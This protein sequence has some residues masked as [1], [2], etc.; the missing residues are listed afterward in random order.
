MS[1]EKSKKESL[2]NSQNEPKEVL[3]GDYIIKKTIGTG[4]FSTVK[5]G[6]H[7]ITQKKVAVKI[8]DKNKIESKDDL[9]RIIREMQIL[10]EMDHQNVIKIFKIYEEEDNFSII[11]EYCEGG[12]LFNYIVK[13]QRLS[14]DETCFFFYQIINGIEYI[15]SKGIAHRDLKP[16]NLLIGKNQILKIIDFGLSNFYDG[17]KRLETPCGSPCYAS[18]EMVKGKKYDGFNIDI[19]AIGVI[20]FAMLCGYL[21]FE[22]DENDNDILFSQIIKNK[23]DYPSFLSELS[24]DM[25]KKILVSDPLKRITVDEIKKHDFYLKGEKIY[26]ERFKKVEEVIN[27]EKNIGI[28]DKIA[29]AF[30]N[31][32][33]SDK[34]II[35][36]TLN[37]K[38]AEK[39]IE[40]TKNI[41][42]I[43]DNYEK[44]KDEQI[45]NNN[46]NN[47]KK[48]NNE[49]H[50]DENHNDEIN[51]YNNEKK[52][53]ENNVK[54]N[55]VENNYIEKKIVE[56]TEN[57]EKNYIDK[58]SAEKNKDDKSQNILFLDYLKSDKA[59]KKNNI[60][61]KAPVSTINKE[62]NNNENHK[63]VNSLNYTINNEIIKTNT[64]KSTNI[65]SLTNNTN[66][67]LNENR[68]S[69]K[70]T[71]PNDKI[72]ESIYSKINNNMYNKANII[73]NIIANK[74]RSNDI[75][76]RTKNVINF[77]YNDIN[78]IINNKIN[79]NK[80]NKANNIDNKNINFLIN[81]NITGK[82]GLVNSF[83]SN[84]KK[85]IFTKLQIKNHKQYR[86]GIQNI[87][88]DTNKILRNKPFNLN[89]DI[90]KNARNSFEKQNPKFNDELIN[91][92][93][94]VLKTKHNINSNNLK[95]I[96]KNS[97]SKERETSLKKKLLKYNIMELKHYNKLINQ[98][99]ININNNISKSVQKNMM[100]NYTK[101]MLTNNNIINLNLI[102]NNS[103]NSNKNLDSLQMIS[104]SNAMKKNF[105]TTPSQLRYIPTK[106]STLP[107]ITI[108]ERIKAKINPNKYN[109]INNSNI[110]NKYLGTE[111]NY[112]K[113][114][115]QKKIFL[116]NAFKKHEYMRL[117][118]PKNYRI[119]S[120]INNY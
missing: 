62:E 61:H 109:S 41:N 68:N 66:S 9:E 106:K 33:D 114:E 21:P 49:K 89:L 63:E 8:L 32:D 71:S 91:L 78:S 24:L 43:K 73:R 51:K 101:P 98:I 12:E 14:E 34:N 28:L 39:K 57:I 115:K 27:K 70:N 15:H 102:L 56:N 18:P 81:G 85:K 46:N 107:S 23:I 52:D 87:I 58:N 108:S 6:V 74:N 5:L 45:N 77:N 64:I 10:T 110:N 111:T 11:M 36:I 60:Q 4:T 55:N 47:G 38:K 7:R 67:T 116:N 92:E 80:Y 22:D 83:G 117:N 2:N 30:K 75:G 13:K 65:N 90:I 84:K 119:N 54:K 48:N 69:N 17:Q 120:N 53:I 31:E 105:P 103:L 37:E 1:Q 99:N 88:S 82:E 112:D 16:E 104:T 72:N 95:I 3:I 20:L 93:K 94:T 96:D 97:K 35:P 76:N 29:Q 25:L 118:Y 40:K 59:N 42:E 86:I 19:W 50:N 44:N 100:A 113:I 79:M 26:N